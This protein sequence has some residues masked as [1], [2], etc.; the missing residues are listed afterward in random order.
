MLK[1]SFLTAPLLFTL[2]TGCAVSFKK[3]KFSLPPKADNEVSVMSFNVENLFDTIH[4]ENREDWTYLPLAMKKTPEVVA[5]CMKQD[6]S[7]RQRECMN[8]DYNEKALKVKMNNI[9]S[10]VLDVDG[11]GP[12][13]LLLVE[14]END[15]VLGQ[16]NREYLD[17]AKYITQVLIEGPDTR[18][19]DVGFLS[20]FPM[21]G[22]PVLHQIP[23]QP[24]NDKDKEWMFRSRNILE[25]NVKAPNG[26]ALTFFVAHFPSQSNPFYWRKQASEALAKLIK[27]K[28]PN[29]MVVAAGD[30]NVTH[31]E[32]EDTKVLRSTLGEVGAISHFVG[33]K[34]CPGTHNY[35]RSWSF[36][37]VQVYSN[38]LLAD[39]SGSYALAPETIDVIRYNPVHLKRAKYPLRW[40]PDRQEG[41]S[42]HFPMYV[43]LKQ[44]SE[45]KNPVVEAKAE[46]PAAVEKKAAEKKKAA[47][48]K[49]K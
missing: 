24:E 49:K 1:I 39:G 7:F 12:D 21:V 46:V 30:L 25:V 48:V 15:R 9:A 44:R 11:Q 23:W 28:G 37:D 8:T 5:G 35:R 33:C 45:A 14:V 38:A 32:E 42:D 43:R 41:V 16:L 47:P 13:N 26:D 36:L 2:L 10:V 6:S 20:R 31:D 27:D 29:A 18:G 19:I 17:K 3:N 22:Q 4:D 40:D 34:E